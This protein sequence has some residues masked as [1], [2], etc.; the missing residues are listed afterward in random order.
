MIFQRVLKGIPRLTSGQVRHMLSDGGILCNWWRNSPNKTLPA[1][2]VRGRL[3]ER[4]IEWHLSHYDDLDPLMGN[5]PFCDNTPFISTTAG[6]IQRNSA[7]LTNE[8]FSSFITALQFAT[9]NFTDDGVIFYAYEF[10]LGK[11]S[12]ELEEFAEETRELNIWTSFQPYHP[13]GEI[14]AKIWI[15][16]QRLESAEFYNGPQAEADWDAGYRPQPLDVLDNQGVFAP[17]ENF[18]NIRNALP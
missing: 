1:N 4:N 14:V 10:V 2:E 13:E 15:P 9:N 18:A 5:E 16:P 12:V 7:L 3:T 6:S 11:K 17:P 8:S